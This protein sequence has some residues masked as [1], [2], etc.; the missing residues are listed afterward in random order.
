MTSSTNV[1]SCI[2]KL[3]WR[4][5]HL[6]LK[7]LMVILP[8]RVDVVDNESDDNVFIFSPCHSFEMLPPPK[9]YIIFNTRVFPVIQPKEFLEA[10]CQFGGP[11]S[12]DEGVAWHSQIQHCQWFYFAIK[13][14][15]DSEIC[16]AKHCSSE[17]EPASSKQNLCQSINSGVKSPCSL[18]SKV[19]E[20][21]K[22]PVTDWLFSTVGI[23][24]CSAVC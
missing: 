23:L 4:G 1:L 14:G 16:T 17:T 7:S 21:D 11:K 19:I 18:S 9:K 6:I 12:S 24:Q 10:V 20:G 22:S 13:I 8:V 5:K 3:T 15:S 2:Q